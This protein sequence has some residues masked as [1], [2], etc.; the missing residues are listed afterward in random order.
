MPSFRLSF[1]LGPIPCI[2]GTGNGGIKGSNLN[3]PP[4]TLQP[5]GFA[6]SA[7]GLNIQ[8]SVSLSYGCLCR[9]FPAVSDDE[10]RRSHRALQ[11][12]L[13]SLP[14]ESIRRASP[15]LKSLPESSTFVDVT[16]WL[17]FVLKTAGALRPRQTAHAIKCRSFPAANRSFSMSLTSTSGHAS[18]SSFRDAIIN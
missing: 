3:N 6:P 13:P 16:L 11:L 4:F 8:R 2:G 18:A 5:E 7:S 10:F 1:D 14:P 15:I 17:N 9:S 12:H